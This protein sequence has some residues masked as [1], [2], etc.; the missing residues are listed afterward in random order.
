MDIRPTS[1]GFTSIEIV[2]SM[3]LD[4]LSKE[5]FSL[6][7]F[8]KSK[9]Q[10]LTDN[11]FL[12]SVFFK[13][14]SLTKKMVA[15]E[16]DSLNNVIGSKIVHFFG[17]ID[18]TSAKPSYDGLIEVRNFKK[19]VLTT[20]SVVKGFIDKGV[21]KTFVKTPVN[22]NNSKIYMEEAYDAILPDAIVSS[23]MNNGEVDW[24]LWFHLKSVLNIGNTNSYMMVDYFHSGGGG[25][26]NLISDV[27]VIDIEKGGD[28]DAIDLEE[29]INCFRNVSNNNATYTISIKSDIPIDQAPNNYL[30]FSNLTAGHVFL[31]FTKKNT[32]GGYASQLIG[33]YPT[34]SLLS[35]TSANISSKLVDNGEHEFNATYLLT[36]SS[37]QFEAAL[38]AVNQFSKN[39]YNIISFNCSDFALAVLKATNVN[40]NSPK[41][42]IPTQSNFGYLGNSPQSVYAA[43]KVLQNNGNK[44]A[45]A[46]SEKQFA[47]VS[48]MP[49]Y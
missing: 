46:G 8:P 20:S 24:M 17:K 44:N 41:L 5:D 4:S 2:K 27:S 19:Q 39:D 30:S 1:S 45:Q 15:V 10:K 32:S 40:F 18:T 28:K 42:K 43:I 33:F 12:V 7:D 26:G 47:A 34:N 38:N 22:I 6:L 48:Y 13:E 36:I 14:G 11:H 9:I 16:L 31:E 3:L 49:C 21:F 29:M 25:G 37:T 23:T 35:I